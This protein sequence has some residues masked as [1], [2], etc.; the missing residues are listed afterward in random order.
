M[1][2]DGAA[3]LFPRPAILVNLTQGPSCWWRTRMTLGHELCHLLCDSDPH[4]NRFAIFSPGAL[5]KAHP[6]RWRLFDGFEHIERRANAFAACLLAPAEA[7]KRI[8]A[9][10]N[11]TSEESIGLVGKTFGLGRI[12]A[13]NRLQD[14]FEF[15]NSVRREM[16]D[17]SARYWREDNHE[18]QVDEEY[19]GL[20]SG[21]LAELALDALARGLIDRVRV[22]SYLNLPMTEPLPEHEGL[23]SAQ[24]APLRRAED[25]VMAIAQQHLQKHMPDCLAETVEPDEGGWR[26]EVVRRVSD[27]LVP[28]GH[29]VVSYEHEVCET[30]IAPAA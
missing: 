11:P 26:V 14:V 5:L 16:A 30:A 18:D 19:I 9:K 3:T 23:T 17:R 8:V 12:T 25:R 13:I 21:L 15:H 22:R 1:D 7:V 20:R 24:R 28:C 29:V 10:R 6:E 2:I 27:E 4:D